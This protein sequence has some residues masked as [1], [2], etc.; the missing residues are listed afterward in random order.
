ME[1]VKIHLHKDESQ[2]KGISFFFPFFIVKVVK[3]VQ[4]RSYEEPDQK[5]DDFLGLIR[6]PVYR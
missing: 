1:F 6:R 4:N 2:H 3:V 5:L